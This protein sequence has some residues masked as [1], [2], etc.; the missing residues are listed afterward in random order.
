[1]TFYGGSEFLDLKGSHNYSTI[2]IFDKE[3]QKIQSLL[4]IIDTLNYETYNINMTT[5]CRIQKFMVVKAQKW[6]SYQ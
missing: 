5:I 6:I 2:C 3:K 4:V 1:M